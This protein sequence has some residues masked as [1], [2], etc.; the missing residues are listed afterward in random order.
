M[1]GNIGTPGR[2]DFTVIGSAVN[3]A[4]RIEDLCKALDRNILLSAAFARLCPNRLVS[5]GRHTLRGVSAAQEL[6]TLPPD[7]PPDS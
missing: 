5:L 1:Y 7:A 2:L 6:F 4:S 3:E